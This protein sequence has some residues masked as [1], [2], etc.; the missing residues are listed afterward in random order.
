ML[1]NNL[2]LKS[3][4]LVASCS[5]LPI[6]ATIPNNVYQMLEKYFQAKE[7]N[8]PTITQI[9]ENGITSYTLPGE[10]SSK[11][12]AQY[13]SNIQKVTCKYYPT[14][15]KCL[16]EG[17][18]LEDNDSQQIYGSLKKAYEQQEDRKKQ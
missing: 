5:F 7:T 1:K 9:L 12:V 8:K 13:D 18:S 16:M 17:W 2:L 14:N 10:F 11:L 3:V 6:K 4:L 15:V